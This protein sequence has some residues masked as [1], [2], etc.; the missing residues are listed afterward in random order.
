[1]FELQSAADMSVDDNRM[2]ALHAFDRCATDA[3]YAAWA[4]RYGRHLARADVNEDYW[5]PIELM[6]SEENKN[7]CLQEIIS[8]ALAALDDEHETHAAARKLA[9]KILRDA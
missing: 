8:D 7:E 4:R 3:D 6:Y 5:V 1:M 9:A 2:D